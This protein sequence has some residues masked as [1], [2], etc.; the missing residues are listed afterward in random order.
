[1]S[2]HSISAHEQHDPRKKSGTGGRK[3]KRMAPPTRGEAL[4]KGVFMGIVISGVTHASKSI[5]G[6]LVR[7]PLALFATGVVSGYLTHKYRKEIILVGSRTAVE[8]KNF[9]LR[10]RESVLDL[11]AE[12]R[13]YAARR[14]AAE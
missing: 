1:M 6:A 11:V 12:S 7:H 4:V 9:L 2:D 5:T 3:A 10:Q 14:D 13:E 8:S